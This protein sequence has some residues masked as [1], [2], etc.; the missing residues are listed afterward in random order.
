VRVVVLPKNGEKVF[1]P[2]PSV[3]A[4]LN[5]FSYLLRRIRT[6]LK[7]KL[8]LSLIAKLRTT[9]RR[10]MGIG[11]KA[12]PFLSMA[13][14]GCEVSASC[15]CHFL[16]GDRISGTYWIGGWVGLRASL[17]AME[18]RKMFCPSQE[19]NPSCPDHSLVDI[20]SCP[21]SSLD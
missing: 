2:K 21:S 9:P 15:L 20:L 17:D 8:P 18:K 4:S 13:L 3:S 1:Q 10:H 6:D 19:M 12:P 5:H 14:D 16:L 7:L 11:D